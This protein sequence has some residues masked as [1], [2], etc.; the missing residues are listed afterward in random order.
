MEIQLSNKYS[1]QGLLHA[2]NIFRFPNEFKPKVRTLAFRY[3]FQYKDKLSRICPTTPQLVSQMMEMFNQIIQDRLDTQFL[4]EI[5]DIL[6]T[7]VPKHG[8]ILLDRIRDIQEQN[9][10]STVTVEQIVYKPIKKT[11]YSDSQNV[12]NT[13]INQSVL[14]ATKNLYSMYKDF[15]NIAGNELLLNIRDI[16]CSKYSNNIQLINDSIKYIKESVATFT[17]EISLE[18]TF[19]ALWLWIHEQKYIDELELRL[20]DELKEM[21]GQCST[22][23]LARLINVIQGYTNDDKLTIRISNKEQCNSVIRNYLT[24]KL[25]DCTDEKVIEGVTD[26]SLEYIEFIRLCIAEKLLEWIKDYG[27]DFLDEIIS[28]V[29]NFCGVTIFTK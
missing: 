11:I 3:L 12:H 1:N 2:V 4:Y 20:L 22:G 27:K 14:N 17:I 9:V 19:K 26:G 16:L 5:A 29:N 8:T 18:D 13:E 25:A 10:T 28:I 23:H 24:K 21:N 7:Y 15:I 6:I